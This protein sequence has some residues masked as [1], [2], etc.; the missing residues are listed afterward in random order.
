MVPLIGNSSMTSLGLPFL[1][2]AGKL[3]SADKTA[4]SADKAAAI[5]GNDTSVL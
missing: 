5:L 1:S 3:S 2:G 4:A